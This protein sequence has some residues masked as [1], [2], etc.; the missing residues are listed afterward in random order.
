VF[1]R[2]IW[3]RAP[4]STWSVDGDVSVFDSIRRAFH[5]IVQSRTAA[6]EF[7]QKID[8]LQ[9]G[10]RALPLEQARSAAEAALADSTRFHVEASLPDGTELSE[11]A[12]D[13]RAF[14]ER[15]ARVASLGAFI[16]ELG[17]H[18]IRPSCVLNGYIAI[19]THVEHTELAARPGD[20]TIWVLAEDVPPED[21]V[22]ESFPSIYH[23]L[24]FV[25]QFT[26]AV[27]EEA[28]QR[29]RD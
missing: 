14:F 22:E 6:S 2:L 23:Y 13:L 28:S 27:D 18:T 1:V 8:Q 26:R 24:L 16:S 12:P 3:F 25:D 10:I 19:G 11:L 20:E 15:Y 17:H 4:T 21:A 5:N 29:Q 9:S 7:T